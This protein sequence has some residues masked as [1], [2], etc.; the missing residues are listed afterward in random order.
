VVGYQAADINTVMTN[1]GEID[2]KNGSNDILLAAAAI[3]Y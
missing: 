3:D 1:F 2:S